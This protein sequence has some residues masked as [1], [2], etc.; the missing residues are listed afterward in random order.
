MK[1][2]AVL[3]CKFQTEKETN[4]RIEWKKKG[5]DVSY[6]YFDG[7]FTGNF[8]FEHVFVLSFIKNWIKNEIR[9]CLINRLLYFSWVVPITFYNL[10][11]S[12]LLF[13]WYWLS[14]H[15]HQACLEAEHQSMERQWPCMVLIRKTRGS[16]TV[17]SLHAK[18]RSVLGKSRFPSLFLV[19]LF[20]L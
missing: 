15:F 20:S 6:V 14:D 17:K 8:F 9:I 1:I 12:G 4:P 19:G 7:E 11:N 18:T 10:I 13:E 3:S 5:R 16:T 2:D